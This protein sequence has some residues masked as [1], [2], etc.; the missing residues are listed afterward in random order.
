MFNLILAYTDGF[1]CL[2]TRF[3]E[4][5]SRILKVHY[6]FRILSAIYPKLGNASNETES[7]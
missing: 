1:W 7:I 3:F 4:R 6:T 2:E 5:S